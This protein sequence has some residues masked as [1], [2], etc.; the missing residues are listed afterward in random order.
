MYT[1]LVVDDEAIVCQGIK[2]FLEASDLSVSRVLTAWN[3]FE[4]LDYLRMES[5]D[6]VLTDIQMD[7]MNGIELMESILAE[8]PDIPVVVISAHDEFEY[9]QKCIRLGARD[10]LI[11]PVHLSQLVQVVGRVLS[12]RHNKF[13]LLLEESL[14][15]KFS[16]TGI[17]SLRTYILNEVIYGSLEHPDDYPYVFEQIGF[18]LEGPY[19][20]V[21]VIE[22][23][24]KHA[25]LRGEAIH[26]LRDRNLLKYA[27]VNIIEETLR[28]WKALIFYGQGNRIIMILQFKEPDGENSTRLN[29]IGKMMV[30][31]IR[32]YLQIEAIIGISSPMKSLE[33]LPDGYS[34]A[35]EAAKWHGWYENHNVYY[36]EDFSQK[37]TPVRGNW[38][39]KTDLFVEWLKTGKKQENVRETVNIFISEL[40]DAFDSDDST[41]GIPLSI[42]Y[43]VYAVLL[44]MKETIGDRYKELDPILFFDFP[45]KGAEIRK[46]LA[47]FL[48]EAAQ[49]V[50][51]AMADHDH[52]IVQQSIDYIRQNYRNKGLKILDVADH[53][54][55]S[56]NYLS[57]LFK[58]IAGETVWEFVT[59][60]R[61]EESRYL[62]TNTSKKRYEIADEVGYE[63]P[64]HFSRVFKR[65]YG[66][67]PNTVRG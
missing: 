59:K 5:V 9:A 21:Y 63:S 66:E 6:L 49:L 48:L 42:A 8:K 47:E 30:G 19:Y 16:M 22:L 36:A 39:K 64:E 12:E 54:H 15:V 57:C 37:V 3:G 18:T 20:S 44:D 32:Q 41:A 60:L 51:T 4:A 11:K 45:L 25:G 13:A 14:K 43:R 55:L 62:L 35:V 7:G 67:S 33:A 1:I 17:S 52:A 46:R 31:N 2:E 53:V 29:L 40:S 24:W 50:H 23:Q 34:Q 10:Y 27:A 61:M 56:P 26:K 58:Q 65:F 28:D 38:Q